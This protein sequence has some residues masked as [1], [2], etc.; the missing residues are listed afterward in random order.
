[1]SNRPRRRGLR[2]LVAATALIAIAAGVSDAAVPNSSSA[3]LVTAPAAKAAPELP[4]RYIRLLRQHYLP[5]RVAWLKTTVPCQRVNFDAC[6]QRM[7]VADAAAT[8]L[9]RALTNSTPPPQ[10]RTGDKQLERGMRAIRA[11]IRKL[12]PALK[13]R[14]T[15][16]ISAI[17]CGCLVTADVVNGIG[18]LNDALKIDLPVL[19]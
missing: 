3:A 17:G 13:S 9:Q 11:H 16:R 12:L 1:M 2:L 14:D 5:F 4:A 6:A 10:A 7:R 8:G 19:G 15:N 18:E